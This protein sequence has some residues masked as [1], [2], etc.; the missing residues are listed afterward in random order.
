MKKVSFLIGNLSIGGAERV[1]SNLSLHMSEKI[2]KE[3]ILFGNKCRVDY[4]Y[5][6]KLIYLDKIE[7]KNVLYKLYAFFYR[8]KKIKSIYKKSKF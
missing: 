8:I 1:V 6:G 3:I 7:H 5:S 4:P 2:N